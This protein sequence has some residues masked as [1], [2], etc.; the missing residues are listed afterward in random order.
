MRSIS[1]SELR[2]N[3]DSILDRVVE[4]HE[5][6]TITRD[7]G[8]PAAVLVSLEEFA[9]WEE[10]LYLLRSPANAVRLMEATRALESDGGKAGSR[11]S[12]E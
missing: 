11:L 9:S 2:M 10:T 5:P 3:L 7:R 12:P 1:C 8:T 6:V 4:D